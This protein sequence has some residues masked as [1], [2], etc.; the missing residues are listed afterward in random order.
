MHGNFIDL[1]ELIVLCRDK[2][3]KKFIQEAVACYRAGA[4]RSCIVSTWNAV[5]FDFLHK[6]RQLEQLGDGQATEILKDFEKKSLNSDFKGLWEFESNIPKEAL[7]KFELIS[8]VEQK[9]IIRL[10]EDRSRCAHPSMTSLEE[11]FEATAELARYHLRSAVMQFLQYPPV[12]GRAA[13]ERIFLD[14]KSEHFPPDPERA[15]EYFKKGPLAHARFALIKDIVTG[16]TVSLLTKDYSENEISRQFSALQA[17]S[18]MYYRETNQVLNEKLSNII[19]DK[20]T[21]GNWSKV[22]IYLAKITVWESLSEPCKLKANT[23]IE[24]FDTSIR[25]NNLDILVDAAHIDFLKD[26]VRKKLRG[27]SLEKLFEIQD[28]SAL[29]ELVEPALKEQISKSIQLYIDNFIE[30]KNYRN[31]EANARKLSTIASWLKPEQWKYLLDGFCTNDQI[32]DATDCPEI[33]ASLFQDSVNQNGSIQPYWINF[34]Q[35]LDEEEF[36]DISAIDKLKQLI[37]YRSSLQ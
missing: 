32:Y 6:L 11:P 34:R 12:Q 4:Y 10:F 16:L 9:D 14:I 13:K 15:V 17:V 37:D 19:L 36:N 29:T 20:V 2:S 24:N 22:I 27:I 18:M 26:A 33:I 5:V 21:D 28:I 25:S 35:K 23:F 3:T 8:P 30:S 1:D 31:A 7:G